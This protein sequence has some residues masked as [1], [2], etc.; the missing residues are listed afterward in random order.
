MEHME[1]NEFFWSVPN[2]TLKQAMKKR[3]NNIKR[4]RKN[5]QI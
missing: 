4:M 3:K 5:G 1:G 2:F